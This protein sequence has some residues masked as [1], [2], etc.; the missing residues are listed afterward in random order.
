MMV[1]W[2][3]LII[4]GCIAIL[5]ALLV[6]L[7]TLAVRIDRLHRRLVNTRAGLGRLTVKRASD[8]LQVGTSG[9]IDE[10]SAKRIN[11]AARA[12]LEMS[13]NPLADDA[14]GMSVSLPMPGED[15][16]SS[17]DADN[18]YVVESDLSAALRETLDSET[19]QRLV[20][21]PWGESLL[22]RLDSTNYR[23]KVSRTM[24]NQDVSQV[25][26]LRAT[27]PV[28]VFHLAGFAPLPGYIDFDD[29]I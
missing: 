22:E 25:R 21:D 9:L 17:G 11:A 24:H 12:S 16:K 5:V 19:R 14:L 29:D 10:G 26:S 23:L 7:W 8:A 28:R 3:W 20:G 13:E 15:H 27:V 2:V 1:W 18:R 6:R 4:A